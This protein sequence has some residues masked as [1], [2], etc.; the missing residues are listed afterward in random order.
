MV[1][2]VFFV[3]GDSTILPQEESVSRVLFNDTCDV[4][5]ETEDEAGC[6]LITEDSD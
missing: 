3:C 2:R 4:D 6:M 1:D 5:T